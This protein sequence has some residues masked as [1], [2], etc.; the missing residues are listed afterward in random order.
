MESKSMAGFGIGLVAGVIIGGVIALLY[1]P[2]SG[3]DTREMI[4]DKAM[5]TR[6]RAVEIADRVKGLAAATADSVRETASDTVD[7]VREAASE[8]NRKGQAAIHALKS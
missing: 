5:E 7:K 8:A 4:K 3:K 6:D 1:V 2:K